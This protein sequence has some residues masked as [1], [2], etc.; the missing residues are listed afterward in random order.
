MELTIG[1]GCI[2]VGVTKKEDGTVGII[3]EQMEEPYDIGSKPVQSRHIPKVPFIP[4]EKDFILWVEN[5]QS[6]M[7]IKEVIDK[8]CLYLY[9]RDNA[10]ETYKL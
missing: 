1:R 8:T 5:F 10:K 6:A 4:T 3:F 9:G 2:A 7:V